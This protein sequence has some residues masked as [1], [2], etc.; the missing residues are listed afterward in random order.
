EGAVAHAALLARQGAEYV[1]GARY[2]DVSPIFTAANYPPLY[3]HIAGL[4]DPFIAGRI[5]SGVA[6]LAIAAAIALP[7]RAARALVSSGLALSW[8]ATLA[9]IV[10]GGARKPALGA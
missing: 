8:I 2:G 3:F 5:A 7:P 4:G 1:A 9:V 10:W 6:A